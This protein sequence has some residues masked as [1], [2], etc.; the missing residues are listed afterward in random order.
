MQ[1]RRITITANL[2]ASIASTRNDKCV[3][4]RIDLIAPGSPDA[5][6]VRAVIFFD[7]LTKTRPVG[8]YDLVA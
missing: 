4:R 1:C 7:K 6:A 5:S 3:E 2:R 8:N